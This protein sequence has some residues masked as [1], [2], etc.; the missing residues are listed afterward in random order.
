MCFSAAA[1]FST[2][3]VLLVVGV[4][5]ISKVSK[6]SQLLFA[7]TPLI[8][9]LQ[10][11]S[12]GVLWLDTGQPHHSM[13]QQIVT[14]FFVSVGLLVW[15]VWVPLAN[16]LLE[17][18][19]W[20]RKILKGMVWLGVVI[21]AYLIY[22]NVVGQVTAQATDKHVDYVFDYPH[23]LVDRYSL[24]YLIPT[25]ISHFVSSIKKINFLGFLTL[26]SFLISKYF[27]I[28]FVFSIWCFFAAILSISIYFIIVSINDNTN[29]IGSSIRL[30]K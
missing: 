20:R 24:F 26:I 17:K 16:L 5:S 8:F 3:G 29:T 9:S 11:L 13:Y 22:Q 7:S 1:S 6:P 27:Y 23:S 14:Y 18:G 2:S 25:V 28:N 30:S 15:P 21:A 4:A 19:K 12:E 10:Q